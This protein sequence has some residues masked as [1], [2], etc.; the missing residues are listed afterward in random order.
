MIEE[1]R[2]IGVE[3]MSTFMAVEMIETA[4]DN[5]LLV[6][7]ADDIMEPDD[8]IEAYQFLINNGIIWIM[9]G[10]YGRMAEY[11]IDYGICTCDD[12]SCKATLD[13]FPA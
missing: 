12:T 8:V 1:Y 2:V 7:E 9:E 5:N 3:K 11:L 13:T 10:T 4:H 6:S